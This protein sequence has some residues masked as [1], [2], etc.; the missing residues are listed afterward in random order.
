MSYCT[1]P[2]QRIMILEGQFSGMSGVVLSCIPETGYAKVL[3]DNG[4][5]VIL[6]PPTCYDYE[7]IENKFEI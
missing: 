3:L 4:T 6:I 1:K 2:D 7:V 5:A